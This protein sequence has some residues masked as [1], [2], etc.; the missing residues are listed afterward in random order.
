MRNVIKQ[1]DCNF[2]V[3]E[4]A[5]TVVC[6]IP[7]TRNLFTR[8]A[9]KY[10]NYRGGNLLNSVTHSWNGGIYDRFVMPNSFS[11]KA[12]CAPEDTWDEETGRMIAFAKAKDKAYQCF[13]RRANAFMN[14]ISEAY[15]DAVYQLNEFGSRLSEKKNSLQHAID[16]R[17]NKE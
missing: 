12:V 16:V 17:V 2:Y 5:R 8:F 11:G 15:E 3:N 9:D 7:H 14:Y 1:K 13:F 4:E 10:F 6:V